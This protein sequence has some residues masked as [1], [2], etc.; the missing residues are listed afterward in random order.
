MRFDL[1]VGS[2]NVCS[3]EIYFKKKTML[4]VL[5]FEPLP[6]KQNRKYMQIV[7]ILARFPTLLPRGFKTPKLTQTRKNVF[8]TNAYFVSVYNFNFEHILH[9]L[10][11]TFRD[12]CE[13][14]FKYVRIHIDSMKNASLLWSDLNRTKNSSTN[15]HTSPPPSLSNKISNF[16]Q[17]HSM[18]L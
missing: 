17:M 10:V 6:C 3:Y 9:P 7:A 1:V 18:V 5:S 11:N 16:I 14:L 12:K 13:L 4:C 15:V 8:K 2:T